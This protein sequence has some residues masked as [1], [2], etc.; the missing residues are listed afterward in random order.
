M[1]GYVFQLLVSANSV[2]LAWN[3]NQETNLA[4]Y[5]LYQ[6]DN[7]RSKTYLPVAEITERESEMIKTSVVVPNLKTSVT[8]T[9]VLTAFT[10]DGLESDYS[11]SVSFVFRP[12]IKIEK[13]QVGIP[14]IKFPMTAGLDYRLDF[15]LD[16]SSWQAAFTGSTDEDETEFSYQTSDFQNAFYRLAVLEKPEAQ[17]IAARADTSLVR[18]TPKLPPLPAPPSLKKP[19]PFIRKLKNFLRYKPGMH[20]K[21]EKGA[22]RLMR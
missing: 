13:N 8:Y 14:V 15:T 6:K 18:I 9:W 21:F 16:F 5:R 3:P 2:T 4:G 22:E 20:P 12:H 11:N 1:L 17:P 19:T 7:A 10:D